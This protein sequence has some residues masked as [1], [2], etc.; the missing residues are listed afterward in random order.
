MSDTPRTDSNLCRYEHPAWPSG[1]LFTVNHN[2]VVLADFAR[3]LERERNELL[4]ALEEIMRADDEA[5]EAFQKMGIP[6][7]EEPP[8]QAKARAAIAKLKGTNHE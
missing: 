3:Q 1:R 6:P 8:T 4:E 2:A 5:E 7:A